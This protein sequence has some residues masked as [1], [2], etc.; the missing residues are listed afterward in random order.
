IAPA[1]QLHTGLFTICPGLK[2]QTITADC[3]YSLSYRLVDRLHDFFR[4]R[5]LG[6]SSGNINALCWLTIHRQGNHALLAEI[7][8]QWQRISAGDDR[9]TGRLNPKQLKRGI[10]G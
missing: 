7:K 8:R 3:G 4:P 5:A 2:T 10:I 9:A 1:I 6:Y